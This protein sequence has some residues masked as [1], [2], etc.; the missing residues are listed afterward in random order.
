[1]A[2]ISPRAQT[3]TVLAE[4]LGTMM[5]SMVTNTITSSG[6]DI[7]TKAVGT[8]AAYA[9]LIT[10]TNAHLNPATSLAAAC[11][12][13]ITVT[14]ALILSTLQITGAALGAMLQALL[15]DEVHLGHRGPG[16]VAT[17]TGSFTQLVGWELLFTTILI[18]A[19]LNKHHG[20]LAVGA[21]QLI[22]MLIGTRG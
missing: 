19:T 21:S 14:A 5:L 20:A 12:R 3:K 10:I 7:L 15:V 1:M 8:G 6:M 2:I 16:C 18:A 13:H 4:L 22:A 9:A 17:D 11:T